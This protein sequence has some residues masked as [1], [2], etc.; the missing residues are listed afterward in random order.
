MRVQTAR[1]FSFHGGSA[2]FVDSQTLCYP[3]GNTVKFEN[4]ESGQEN[5][6]GGLE[7]GVSAVAG[8]ADAGLVVYAE[9]GTSPNVHV[10]S[11]PTLQ[12]V[13][14]LEGSAELEIDQVAV[15][16]DGAVIAVVSGVPDQMLTVWQGGPGWK[17]PS[18]AC[19]AALSP[20]GCASLSICPGDANKLCTISQ[21][22]ELL[23]HHVVED[24]D[25]A[26]SGVILA[27]KSWDPL[28]GEFK[29]DAAV[30]A[31]WTPTNQLLVGLSS[32]TVL[33]L[34]L[35]DLATGKAASATTLYAPAT[36]AD[37]P[38]PAAATALNVSAAYTLIGFGDGIVRVLKDGGDSVELEV[39]SAG[40]AISSI[41]P[42]PS[43]G[44][45]WACATDGSVSCIS[46]K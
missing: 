4:V 1:A 5:F 43:A 16:R 44:K 23:L 22:G 20:A 45:F 18:I 33:A 36:G 7:Y 46:G 41:S 28:P 11:F 35:T 40:G 21:T 17:E 15:S 31:G 3:C 24:I 2:S 42:Q 14:T 29:E 6:L 12:A 13:A 39:A 38:A 19:R 8:C 37:A 26:S 9:K 34:S 32:G 30:S 10:Y 27:L 25:Q